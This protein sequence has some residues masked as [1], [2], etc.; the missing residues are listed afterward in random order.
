MTKKALLTEFVKRT[1][2]V[3]NAK[4][5]VLK[6]NFPEQDAFIND[7]SRYVVAQ[8]S[9]R[10]GKTNGL[11]LR[12]FKTMEKYPKSQC[13]YLAH[14]RD[15]AKEIIWQ[16]LQ[17]HNDANGLGCTFTE[18]K[19]EMTHPN[20]SKLR[21]Y[22][23]DQKHFVKRLRGRKYPGVAIDEAQDFGPHLETLIND[24]VTPSI[25]DY[26]DGWL[27]VTGTPGP[28]P[29][30]YFFDITEKSRYG[31]SKHKWTMLENPYMPDAPAFL[32]D[33]KFKREWDDNNPSFLR[34][35]K[36]Q[37]VLDADSL[38]VRYNKDRADYITMPMNHSWTYV[39][40]IDIGFKDADAV[41][42]VAYSE[43]CPDAYLVEEVIAP[44][45]DITSLIE[46]IRAY[47]AK[48]DVAKMVMDEGGL[49]KKIGEEL[50][51][52]FQ[53]PVLPAVKQNK[54]DNVALLNDAMRMGRFKARSS[55][56]FVSDSYLIQID[57]DKTTPDRIQI[58]KS[59]HSDIIDAVLYAFRESYA[60]TYAKPADPK[61][62]WGTKEWAESQIE[63]L[64]EEALDHFQKA[65]DADKYGFEG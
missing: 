30:G 34:E 43:T 14:T 23:A 39:M 1:D 8:C 50:R 54:Q 15:S 42:I 61:P 35:Y 38:W 10:S 33:L 12:F 65:E 62:K 44:K 58:K 46:L 49:G 5:L 41:A 24:V 32:A 21:I 17:E 37:W 36:N 13:L 6:G 47:Q 52:R 40:G 19:L 25:A 4:K 55:T 60:Y 63:G 56:R 22:G 11:V 26:A 59:P 20:G 3:K 29:Q 51:R 64:F 2:K 53:I 48:Y 45:Q 57:W 7:P 27:A 9:R 18:S 28:V 16:V 31:F